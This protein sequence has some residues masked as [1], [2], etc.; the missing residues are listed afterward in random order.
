MFVKVQGETVSAHNVR[1]YRVAGAR[2]ERSVRGRIKFHV[3]WFM[4]SGSCFMFHGFGIMFH[5]FLF[6]VHGEGFKITV[7][8]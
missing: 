2:R 3:S 7:Q 4:V 1:R 8:V 6:R 5:G